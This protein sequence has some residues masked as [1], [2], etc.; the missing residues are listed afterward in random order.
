LPDHD[1][2]TF[3]IFHWSKYILQEAE[4]KGVKVLRL[5]REKANRKTFFDFLNSHR[6]SFLILNGHGDEKTIY[7]YNDEKML[8]EGDEEALKEKIIYTIACDAAKSLGNTAF[9]QAFLNFLYFSSV[10]L[11]LNI[12]NTKFKV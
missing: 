1:D 7:G 8:E 9:K 12:S 10:E 2:S 11:N 3:Y 5:E 6:P 4:K